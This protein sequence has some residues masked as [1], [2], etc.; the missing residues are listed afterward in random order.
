MAM[1]SKYLF[2]ERCQLLSSVQA[3]VEIPGRVNKNA[4][5][6]KSTFMGMKML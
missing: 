1:H 5:L 4:D 3:P 2:P 6:I